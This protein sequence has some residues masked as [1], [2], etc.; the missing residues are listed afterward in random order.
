MPQTIAGMEFESL[1]EILKEAGNVDTLA[2]P[3]SDI[4]QKLKEP[5]EGKESIRFYLDP[6]IMRGQHGY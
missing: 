3:M 4:V 5:G 6:S 1:S 2:D